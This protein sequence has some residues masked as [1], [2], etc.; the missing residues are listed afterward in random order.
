[1]KCVLILSVLAV[2]AISLT[3]GQ[4]VQRPPCPCP[5]NLDPVCASNG[6]TFSNPCLFNCAKEFEARS[7]RS[8]EIARRGRC[9]ENA[10]RYEYGK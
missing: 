5:R 1:M 8:I 10:N 4:N 9:D 3:S 7:G 2:F 6:E